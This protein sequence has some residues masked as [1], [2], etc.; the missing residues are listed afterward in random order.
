[1][2]KK[3]IK[4]KFDESGYIDPNFVPNSDM[5][6][7]YAV[8]K[9]DLDQKPFIYKVVRLFASNA[10]MDVPIRYPKTDKRHK[11]IVPVLDVICCGIVEEEV[12]RVA[13]KDVDRVY[14][15]ENI[16][17]V[18][19]AR[20][21]KYRDTIKCSSCGFTM[22]PLDA[23]R[24]GGW[25]NMRVVSSDEM[26]YIPRFCPDCGAKMDGEPTRTRPGR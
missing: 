23:Y 3:E 2:E 4:I 26:L 5:F 1:M 22:F 7:M 13:L 15:G 11:E 10:Y 25:A 6:G 19:H 18:V 24:K 20:W 17:P 8:I 14:W 21:E 16:A 9:T 12:I